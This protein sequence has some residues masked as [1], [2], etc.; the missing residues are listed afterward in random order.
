MPFIFEQQISKNE[1][2]RLEEFFNLRWINK[3][4]TKECLPAAKN[5]ELI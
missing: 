3:K 4:S 5:F 1:L 2:S